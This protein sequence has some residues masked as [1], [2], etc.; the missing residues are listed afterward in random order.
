MHFF[1]GFLSDFF[2]SDG[3]NFTT[4]K[5]YAILISDNSALLWKKL[6][7]TLPHGAKGT[8]NIM[9][10][11]KD[12]LRRDGSETEQLHGAAEDTYAAVDTSEDTDPFISDTAAQSASGSADAEIAD[13]AALSAE[14]ADSETAGAAA[15]NAELIGIKAADINAA[16]IDTA[17]IDTA[18]TENADTETE[19]T[20]TDASGERSLFSRASSAHARTRVYGSFCRLL[21]GYEDRVARKRGLY[22]LWAFLI[23]FV[24]LFC[25]Y[26]SRGVYPFGNGSVLILDLNGQYVYFFA[27][28][29]NKLLHGG[30]LLYS[31]SRS[32]GG[33]FL[34]IFAYYLSSPF[35]LIT[36]LFPESHITE[37]LLLM[38][39]LK[40]GACGFSMALYLHVSHKGRKLGAVVFSTLYALCSYAIVMAHN[41]MWIDELIYLPLL[42]LGIERMIK[43]KDFVLYVAVLALSAMSNFY[44]GY[45]MCIFSFFYFFY[46]YFAKSGNGENNPLGERRHLVRSLVRMLIFS[47]IA[48]EIAAVMLYPAYISL[49]YGKTTFQ[50]P[51][52]ELKTNF[53]LLDFFI[54]MMPTAYD[55]VRPDGLPFIACGSLTLLLM[56]M[57]FFAR[58]PSGREKLAAAG[59]IAVFA[60]SMSLSLPDLVWHG[61]QTPNWLN[62]RYAFMLIFF[63]ITLAYR[64][65]SELRELEIRWLLPVVFALVALIAIAQK[66]CDYEWLSDI[67]VIW[68]TL[69]LLAV[70][71]FCIWA[72]RSRAMTRTAP[73]LLVAA[74]CIETVG[75]GIFLEHRMNG[76][77]V[78]SSRSSYV[79]YNKKYGSMVKA[80]KN[81]DSEHYGSLFYRMENTGHRTVC[82]PMA[83]GEYGISNSSSL[84]NAAVIDTLGDLG[85]ASHSHW[86][87][88]KGQTPVADS[89]LG[90]RYIA[91]SAD[92]SAYG[93]TRILEDADNGLYGYENTN[94]L[95]LF[96]G[97]SDTLTELDLDEQHYSVDP[98]TKMNEII[99]AMLGEDKTVEVWKPI[100]ATLDL[101]NV[102]ESTIKE[103]GDYPRHEKFVHE[104]AGRSAKLTYSFYGAGEDNPI[105]CVFPSVYGSSGQLSYNN[106]DLVKYKKEA[107]EHTIA[108]GA[109]PS[110]AQATVS[111]T[112]T[113]DEPF[114]FVVNIR[115]F[116]YLDTALWEQVAA[117]LAENN[118]SI[119]RFSDTRVEGTVTVPENGM[120][121]TSIPQDSGWSVWVDGEQVQTE[122]VLGSLIAFR[123]APGE[124]TVRLRYLPSCAVYGGII[125][126]AGVVTFAAAI[127]LLRPE[128]ASHILPRRKKRRA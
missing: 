5:R 56:P 18:N 72:M 19:K 119:T 43:K 116:W 47:I 3:K 10:E 42:A 75:V 6:R 65:F 103:S 16:N 124:H 51:S 2:R 117:R 111:V 49:S 12:S 102:R 32:L 113:E 46:Y 85:Y 52:Y 80:L 25:I 15:A 89:L 36:C 29:R 8:V 57:F 101:S 41:T 54:K 105:F 39:M 7:N 73:L 23:P 48:L 81:Y 115:S 120:V 11:N 21:T 108:L 40:A 114:Y 107:V 83:L 55:T 1:I 30:S 78:F 109:L 125:S 88:Y 9:T 70:S 13:A 63:F 127:I 14:A 112:L 94:A 77:V 37:A 20:E 53:D 74:V 95:S 4:R 126:V 100:K 26:L 122:T 34:G 33:E 62:Y 99:T 50:S 104:S 24:L 45:M 44:I 96:Y 84:L 69:G 76:D 87:Q 118:G 98:F 31:W 123:A 71:V 58:K 38:F 106:A 59:F 93:Y 91:D 82:D 86:S 121:F 66:V 28:L 27:E 68:I 128:S 64:A 92:E 17:N 97:V 22:L 90:I 67:Y 110:D 35:S 60:V 61:F 79:D